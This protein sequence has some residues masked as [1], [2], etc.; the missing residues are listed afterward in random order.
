MGSASWR[1]EARSFCELSVERAR[2]VE[3][4]KW[5]RGGG[6]GAFAGATG[7]GVEGSEAWFEGRHGVVLSV[8]VEKRGTGGCKGQGLIFNVPT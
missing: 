2:H 5:W 4:W 8:S 7:E 6:D 3:F 1:W